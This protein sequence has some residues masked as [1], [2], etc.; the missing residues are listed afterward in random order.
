MKLYE[1][2][3]L[4]LWYISYGTAFSAL[5]NDIIYFQPLL[6]IPNNPKRFKSVFS[7]IQSGLLPIKGW[8][9]LAERPLGC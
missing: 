7:P 5:I 9:P 3:L 4:M 6:I 1:L 2:H 8:V